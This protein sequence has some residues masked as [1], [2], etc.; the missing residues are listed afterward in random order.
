MKDWIKKYLKKEPWEDWIL[1]V[2]NR[3]IIPVLW[4]FLFYF[5]AYCFWAWY[6][7]EPIPEVEPVIIQ[8]IIIT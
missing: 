7:G 6:N 1:Y 8:P 5:I 4:L 3:F 2:G